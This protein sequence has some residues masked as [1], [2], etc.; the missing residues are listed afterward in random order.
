MMLK[1]VL[2]RDNMRKVTISTHPKV[3]DIF[4]LI[5]K[6]LYFDKLVIIGPNY[7]FRFW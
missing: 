5:T 6:N 4:W 7:L 2:C 3:F 1:Q